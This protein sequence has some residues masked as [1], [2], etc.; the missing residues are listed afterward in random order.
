M[1]LLPQ[2]PA[3]AP[4]PPP[5][6]AAIISRNKNRW[7]WTL[8]LLS[9]AGFGL[10][11]LPVLFTTRCRG[12]DQVESINNLRQ[13]GILLSEFQSEYGS[14]PAPATRA[15]VISETGSALRLE[16]KTSNDFFRQLVAS[17]IAQSEPIFYCKTRTS[18]KPDGLM[19]DTHLLSKNECGFTYLLG[20]TEMDNPSRP[21]VFAPLFY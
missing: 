17:G 12:H 10:I 8:G 6:R 14:F 4:A 16:T 7:I 21:L 11:S 9:M 18:R 15:A 2:P 5:S 1:S 13:I 19:D 20:A 3:D